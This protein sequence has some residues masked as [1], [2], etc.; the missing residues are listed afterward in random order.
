MAMTKRQQ[1]ELVTGLAFITPWFIGFVWFILYPVLASVYY[2]FTSFHVIET[3]QWVGLGN[4]NTL[5]HDDLFW[6]SLWN[7]AYYIAGSVPL[8]LVAALFL[9]VLLNLSLPF[10]AVLRTA[11]YVPVIVPTVAGAILW[12]MLFNTHG[13]IINETLGLVGIPEVPW[14]SSPDWA[15][16]ALII[17]SVWGIGRAIVIFLAGLQDVPTTLYEAARLD[18]AGPL[19]VVLHVTVPLVSPV[20]LFNGI[21][22]MIDASQV[23]AQ[24]LIMT[25][26]GPL[27]ATL[28]YSIELFR[29]AFV[30]YKMGYASAMAW[31]LFLIIVAASFLTFRTAARRVYYGG[32]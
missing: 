29:N 22:F 12:I 7:T 20:I 11:Y 19:Q 6:I 14:L 21:L 26:G 4:F 17:V 2:S 8:D 24:P 30:Y 31:I 13:G 10:R 28:M 5:I 27:N 9:A 25:G 23:F 3:P 15:M 32:S 18:G 1:S 16:P